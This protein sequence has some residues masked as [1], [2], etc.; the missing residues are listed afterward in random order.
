M[1][2]IEILHLVCLSNF[3]HPNNTA[4]PCC[5]QG[6]GYP[7]DLEDFSTPFQY[8]HDVHVKIAGW[9]AST[10]NM[11]VKL[12]QNS[13]NFQGWI[14]KNGYK[15]HESTTWPTPPRY[16]ILWNMGNPKFNKPAISPPFFTGS[17][18]DG[19][20]PAPSNPPE[21]SKKTFHESWWLQLDIS[22]TRD[23]WWPIPWNSWDGGMAFGALKPVFLGREKL[24]HYALL[25]CTTFW[26][27]NWVRN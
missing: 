6:V 2:S 26:W 9:W 19:A 20:F 17:C 8:C 5:S 24:H 11:L 10:Q 23:M 7:H 14:Y 12:D 1:T 22:C 16:V 18:D 25:N 21:R 3:Q 15:I 13:P 4:S 27:Y